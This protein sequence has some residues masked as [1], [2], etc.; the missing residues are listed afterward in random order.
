MGNFGKL[1]LSFFIAQFFPDEVLVIC[2]PYFWL[3]VLLLEYI[4][5]TSC[6]LI[7]KFVF[8]QFFFLGKK[9]L[10]SVETKFLYIAYALNLR[11]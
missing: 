9:L 2:L 5:L 8:N 11:E 4:L 6:L 10:F 7:S 3:I 1:R